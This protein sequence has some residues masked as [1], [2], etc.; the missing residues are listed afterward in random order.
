MQ[1][2]L[3]QPDGGARASSGSAPTDGMLRFKYA[4][5]AACAIVQATLIVDVPYFRG[6]YMPSTT[7]PRWL[8]QTQR[9]FY[10][11]AG[12]CSHGVF[13]DSHFKDYDHIMAVTWVRPD[14]SEQWLPLTRANGQVGSYAMGRFWCKW[15]IRNNGP[16][17][18]SEQLKTTL[19]EL[20]AFWAR[21]NRVDLGDARF[22][23]L[24]RRY[25]PCNGWQPDYLLRQVEKP[26]SQIGQVQWKKMEFSAEIADIASL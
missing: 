21:K 6:T 11:Y 3:T 16:Y 22:K 15:V 2:G 24:V 23:V 8:T 10:G 12:I 14:G 9:A 4:L 25:D 26:W 13:L 18:T 17:M 19:R 20:T 7:T 1:A 5:V